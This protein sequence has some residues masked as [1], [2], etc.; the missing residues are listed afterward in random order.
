MVR[1]T[2]RFGADRLVATDACAR[3]AHARLGRTRQ[4]DGAHDLGAAHQA[5]KLQSSDSG[6]GVNQGSGQRR[7]ERGRSKEGMTTVGETGL[8][9]PGKSR[10][11][12]KRA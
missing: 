9:E 3:T 11:L 2:C 8:E 4:Q 10:A 12:A 1:Q 7:R 6:R 5:G